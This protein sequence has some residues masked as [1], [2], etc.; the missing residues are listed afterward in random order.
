MQMKLNATI[1]STSSVEEAQAL[2]EQ[3]IG[4]EDPFEQ[5]QIL[6]E[7]NRDLGHDSLADRMSDAGYGTA[8][9]S[10]GADVLARLKSKS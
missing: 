7:I 5:S 9:R 8:N 1:G 4:K 2:I 10:T 6:S 3:V